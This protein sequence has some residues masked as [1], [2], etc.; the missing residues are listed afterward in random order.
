MD[1]EN[2]ILMD[3][4]KINIELTPIDWIV[5]VVN[6]CLLLLLIG[7]PLYY[8][9]D[10]PDKIPVHFNAAGEPDRFG[11]KGSIWFEVFLGVGI[12]VMMVAVNRFP[13]IFNYP[14]QITEQNARKQYTIATRIMRLL[15]LCCLLIFVY[16][17]VKSISVAVG[18]AV[19]LGAW[20][21]PAMTL[22]TIGLSILM[23]VL[24]LRNK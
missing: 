13:H 9:P 4:P 3:R 14:V 17:T 8:L 1:G 15:N 5:E 19:G 10:L 11:G 2:L 12:Y 6:V 7:L 16:I 23:I 18:N 21:L 24:S 22:G 20:F